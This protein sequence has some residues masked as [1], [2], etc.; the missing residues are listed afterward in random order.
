MT[1]NEKQLLRVL[2][3]KLM[4]PRNRASYKTENH[5]D[6]ALE[7]T[8]DAVEKDDAA[9]VEQDFCKHCGVVKPTYK[10]GRCNDCGEPGP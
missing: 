10:D 9:L 7:A 6:R 5:I 4:W 8:V 2:A 1:P 3:A